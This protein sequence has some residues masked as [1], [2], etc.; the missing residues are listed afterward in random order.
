M[1]PEK[2]RNTMLENFGLYGSKASRTRKWAEIAKDLGERQISLKD[3][4][5]GKK[6][7]GVK[8]VFKDNQVTLA[9]ATIFGQYLK[10][11]YD[12][13]TRAAEFVR[14]TAGEKPKVQVELEQKTNPFDGISTDEL[15]AWMENV[16]TFLKTYKEEDEQT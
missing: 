16:T 14:D 8:E 10:S 1:N 5:E 9:E 7:E 11:V 3:V 6:A 13:D 15:S 12:L 2:G 4:Y